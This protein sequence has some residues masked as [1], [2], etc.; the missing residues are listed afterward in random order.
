MTITESA[1]AEFGRDLRAPV[2]SPGQLAH[3][4]ALM[5]LEK[6][7][8]FLGLDKGMQQLLATPRRSLT[9]AV[10]LRRDDGRLEVHTGYRVQHSLTRGPGK[11]GVRFHPATDL[12]EVTALA[13]WMTWKCALLGLPYGGAKGGIAVDVDGFSR[14]EKERMTRR[15][16]QEILPFIGPDKDI[17]AP[18]VNT[19]E[20]TM[21]WMMDTYSVSVGYSVHAA[22]TGKP[23]T[24]GGSNGRA[25]AT[26]RGVVIT[27]LEAMRHKGIDPRNATVAIQGFGKVGAHAARLFAEE[28]CRV[29]AVTDVT[30]GIQQDRGLLIDPLID[31]ASQGGVLT[32]LS[33]FGD[34]ISNKEL[35]ALD[36][37]VLVPAAMD[38]VLTEDNAD[39]VRA[40]L[41]VEGAN[42]PTSPEADAILADNGITVVPDILANAGG[43]VVS[44]LEW[45]QN[46]QA[47][48]WSIEE[49]DRKL[50]SLMGA[51]S[52][53]VWALAANQAISLRL[54]AHALGVG[55]VAEAHRDRGLFP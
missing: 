20:T 15:Y 11:G 6:A 3:R 32:E 33:G 36:V 29:V 37:D 47:F 8:E 24:V 28:G 46:L 1:V 53:T 51:A 19:D 55:K 39:E 25:T 44:Y 17:P 54:A 52:Q 41:V 30:G 35:L 10:P 14:A 34:R 18:D 12:N 2:S 38:G 4:S 23:L 48:S 26:S 7:G 27:A 13:M 9:V 16:T 45:V 43:V 31:R 49:V 40:S 5:Q 21:A 50:T 22:T 42:G